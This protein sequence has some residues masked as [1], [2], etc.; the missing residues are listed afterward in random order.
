M[1]SLVSV[2]R[3]DFSSGCRA[4]LNLVMLIIFSVLAANI[5]LNFRVAPGFYNGYT[6]INLTALHAVDVQSPIFVPAMFF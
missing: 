6:F 4:S 2:V 5:S 1:T 3:T